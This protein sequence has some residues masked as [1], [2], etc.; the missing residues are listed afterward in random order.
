MKHEIKYLNIHVL[1]YMLN[2]FDSLKI[3]CLWTKYV[4]VLVKK[5]VVL[6]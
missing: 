3:S 6:D 5:I 2:L 1:Y 4:A